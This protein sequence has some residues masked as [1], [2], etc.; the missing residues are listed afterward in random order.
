MEMICRQDDIQDDIQEDIQ[1]ENEFRN[2]NNVPEVEIESSDV[3][4]LPR[5]PVGI[6]HS[7][8]K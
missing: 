6:S 8:L 7:E 3:V 2:T 4:G 5:L 1:D